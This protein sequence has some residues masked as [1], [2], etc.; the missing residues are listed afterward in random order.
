MRNWI[1]IPLILFITGIISFGLLF[2]YV[3]QYQ[4]ELSSTAIESLNNKLNTP[5]VIH[6][7]SH[8]NFFQGFPNIALHLHEVSIGSLYKSKSLYLLIPIHE[9]IMKKYNIKKVI[10]EDASFE[11]INNPP[12]IMNYNILK[13]EGKTHNGFDLDIDEIIIKNSSLSYLT[14]E[15]NVV[16]NDLN[17]KIG[18]KLI[19]NKLNLKMQGGLNSKHIIL[20]KTYYYREYPFGFIGDLEYYFKED[21]IRTDAFKLIY[22]NSELDID[23]YTAAISSDSRMDISVIGRAISYDVVN[24]MLTGVKV[25]FLNLTDI[26]GSV[27]FNLDINGSLQKS[28]TT[29]NAGFELNKAEI[30]GQSLINQIS[31]KGE[32]HMGDSVNTKLE[33][34]SFL[35]NQEP[36]KGYLNIKGIEDPIVD[37]Q[38][39]GKLNQ[40]SLKALSSKSE[41][42]FTGGSLNIER[43]NIKAFLEKKGLIP[44][45]KHSK[46]DGY[47]ILDNI[48]LNNKEQRL[49]KLTG[50][51][52]P[53][54]KK[55]EINI[56]G[57]INESEFKFDGEIPQLQDLINKALPSFNIPNK[58][59]VKGYL[60]LNKFEYY[61]Q[62]NTNDSR[63]IQLNQYPDLEI[64]LSLDELDYNDLN[65]QQ[66]SSIIRKKENKIEINN[67]QMQCLEGRSMASLIMKQKKDYSF[68]IDGILS[69]EDINI[70]NLFKEFNN[71]DQ[72]LLKAHH[73]KGTL[74][75][76]LKLNIT[77][78]SSLE[79]QHNN[80][81]LSG[82]YSIKNGELKS[83]E[84][85]I[86][87]NKWLRKNK[88]LNT[89]IKV[90]EFDD[91][92]FG[93][94]KNNLTIKNE[95]IY[96]KDLKIS[97][98][99]A[100]L[101]INGEHK[102]NNDIDYKLKI[103]IPSILNKGNIKEEDYIVIEEKGMNLFMSANGNIDNPI[104]KYDKKEVKKLI[105][106][107]LKEEKEE[108]KNI[109]NNNNKNKDLESQKKPSTKDEELDFDEEIDWEY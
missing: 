44:T 20:N 22:N 35:M 65:I 86:E 38:L 77:A 30:K 64:I 6:G 57:L 59:M 47:V 60:H 19:N 14:K 48:S 93:E 17:A 2:L 72:A 87:L 81:T 92:I 79:I 63:S 84:P 23:G 4:D 70:H 24:S 43:L 41:I 28:Q 82:P 73:L 89:I 12:D 10:I 94:I 26:N 31:L 42:E 109:V 102:F 3:S 80:L 66:L 101:F 37:L 76:Q 68:A 61:T 32:F 55:I 27:D 98:N 49:Q 67:M 45:I 9:V 54:T 90:K 29:I 62:E 99:K 8:L 75:A 71:F 88:L 58:Y 96:F 106:Q 50:V 7:E 13:K 1:K 18:L 36:I 104:L 53:N 46:I 40:K 25:S 97:S 105:K 107:K 85:L 39:E 33:N 11:L 51:I 52:K 21:S 91:I 69:L 56:E 16:F 34:F 5:I 95:T 15:K 100:H 78:K 108:I 103:N 83:F 74:S